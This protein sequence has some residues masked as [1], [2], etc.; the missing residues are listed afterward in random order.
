MPA[1]RPGGIR[2][3]IIEAYRRDLENAEANFDV[4][5]AAN[6]CPKEDITGFTAEELIARGGFG[7]VYKARK[8]GKVYAIKKQ[9]KGE[10]RV[11][12]IREKKTQYAFSNIFLVEL[13]STCTTPSQTYMIMEYA[14]YGDLYNIGS[15]PHP[16]TRLKVL[17]AQVVLG[18]EYI[19]R[20][21]LI[22]RDLK[23]ANILVFGKGLLKICDFGV[24]VRAS[25]EPR[26]PCGTLRFTSPEMYRD[27][28][29][30]CAVDWWALGIMMY[31]LLTEKSAC[32][33]YECSRL[34]RSERIELICL[35]E[36]KQLQSPPHSDQ[37]K[38]I[39]AQLLF[40]DSKRRL[41]SG[42]GG[43][44]GLKKHAWFSD[45]DFDNL[46]VEQD[47][48]L[49]ELP[50]EEQRTGKDPIHFND[51]DPQPSCPDPKKDP[52]AHF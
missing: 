52:Y 29:Y 51:D 2:A 39:M 7:T 37:A 40:K 23:P 4:R 24:T 9:P 17:L 1:F 41:G 25:S 27:E 42:S 44:E 30:D 48:P 49:I 5:Y 43:C 13:L 28:P 18:L 14:P 3:E 32:P 10:R 34:S 16:E 31:E 22:Y 47:F 33:F 46:I 38:E 50:P 20:C 8:D 36:P 12:L 6:S 19:H 45:I 26:G 35:T 11:K 15:I 21:N